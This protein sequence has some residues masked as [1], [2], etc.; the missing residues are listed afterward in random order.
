VTKI[1]ELRHG[2]VAT[3]LQSLIP[4]APDQ[5]MTTFHLLG[6]PTHQHF[7][8]ATLLELSIWTV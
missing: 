6:V 7:L 3:P 8:M 5:K 2:T 4:D 1:L